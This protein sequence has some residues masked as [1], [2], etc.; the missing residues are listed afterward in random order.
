MNLSTQLP[1]Q[2]MIAR[3]RELCQS[4]D[5]L[6]SAMMYGSF[7]LGESDEYSD[8]EFLLFFRDDDFDAII[9]HEWLSQIE[10]VAHHYTN[11]WGIL[12]VIFENLVRGE[13]HI[14]RT[15][16]LDAVIKSLHGS[17]TFPSLDATLIADKSGAMAPL[18]APTIGPP[19]EHGSDAELQG[20]IDGFIHK[21]LFGF[22][23]LQRGELAR[24]LEMLSLTQRTLLQMARVA[25]GQTTHWYIPSRNLESELSPDAY[26]R[27]RDCTA[28]LDAR[29]LKRAYSKAWQWGGELMA[30]LRTT[31]D[32]T[33][34]DELC[35][36]ILNKVNE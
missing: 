11:E 29:A 24:A 32:V 14:H 22:Q 10:P 4:D 16:E 36:Q 9:P 6:D 23:V 21:M 13:F 27:F 20:L 1:Q 26:A 3:A 30:N 35:W 2:R 12:A 17:E 33:V 7:A 15:S 18:L 19:L 31:H 34:P 8:I 25:E 28:A 5:R